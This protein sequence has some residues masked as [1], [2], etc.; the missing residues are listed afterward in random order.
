VTLLNRWKRRLC[1][2]WWIDFQ[3]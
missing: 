2:R 3:L 1:I